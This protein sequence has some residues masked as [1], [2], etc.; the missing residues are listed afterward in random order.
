MGNYAAIKEVGETLINILWNNIK[1][2]PEMDD[3]ILS[4][5]QLCLSSPVEIQ[6]ES[7][8]RLAIFL[9]QITECPFM[10]N[11]EMSIETKNKLKYPALYLALHYLIT[12]NTS[13]TEKDH[14][15]LGKV[16]QTFQDN[17]IIRGSSLPI[18][19]TNNEELRLLLDPLSI[20]DLNKIWAV[21]EKPYKLS[22]SYI[23][24]PVGIISKREKDITR[25]LEKSDK[26]LAVRRKE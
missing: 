6:S 25:V 26:Y 24:T 11:Q 21:L 5:D 3:I 23:V 2:D 17:A 9:Y 7:S 18:G 10:K 1:D 16:M 8:K 14:I 13:N 4:E 22:I 20:D 19:W 12:P 15:L